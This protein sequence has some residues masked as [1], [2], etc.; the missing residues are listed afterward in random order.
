MNAPGLLV[1]HYTHYGL[2]GCWRRAQLKGVQS[3]EF[4]W[5]SG[6][7]AAPPS[8]ALCFRAFLGR[9]GWVR[10]ETGMAGLDHLDPGHVL[11]DATRTPTCLR[12]LRMPAQC[13]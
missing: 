8:H 12:I 3:Q 13:I 4:H 6:I 1:F 10:P 5:S 11:P 2:L 7:D 9:G